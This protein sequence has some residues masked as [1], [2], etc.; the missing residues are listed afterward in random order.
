MVNYGDLAYRTGAS[1]AI[2][3]STFD[4]TGNEK[5]E[6]MLQREYRHPYRHPYA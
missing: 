2:R 3:A 4:V 1:M 6:A 5:A